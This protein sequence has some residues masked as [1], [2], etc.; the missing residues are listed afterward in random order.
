M[1]DKSSVTANLPDFDV[2]W[3]YDAPAETETKFREL[4]PVAKRS[5]NQ[6]YCIELLTQIARTQGLQRNFAEAH[7]T[8]DQVEPLLTDDMKRARVRYLLERGRAFNS[9]GKPREAEPLFQAAWELA[10]RAGED[11]LAI[12]AAHMVAIAARSEPERAL[13][14]N[15]KALKL[16]EESPHPTARKW[17]GSLYN[18]IGWTYHDTKAFDKALEIFQKALKWREEVGKVPEIRI[19]RWC[20]ARTL[21]CQ[22]HL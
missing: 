10:R 5:G 7:R 18:N 16:A 3:N 6:A 21:R 13:E 22:P 17:L 15:L 11:A 8:L 1:S 2:L 12:D 20:M 14:W 19:A 4:L 9:W